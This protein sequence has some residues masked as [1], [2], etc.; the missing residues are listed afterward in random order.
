MISWRH[1]KRSYKDTVAQANVVS[2]KCL[3]RQVEE[4]LVWAQVP[5]AV[6]LQKLE[7]TETVANER[8]RRMTFI[9][10]QAMR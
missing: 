2:I 5:P 7:D 4:E 10:Y 6:A 8:D 9:K 3:I 1:W